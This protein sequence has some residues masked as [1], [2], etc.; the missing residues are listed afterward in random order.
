MA[1]EIPAWE[2]EARL[3]DVKSPASFSSVSELADFMAE[4]FGGPVYFTWNDRDFVWD[5]I[6]GWLFAD[7]SRW[8]TSGHPTSD[9]EPITPEFSSIEEALDFPVLDGKSV[10]ERFAECRFFVE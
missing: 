4:A 7:F 5:G 6:S 9:W 8:N 10:R 1:Q 3:K 2:N